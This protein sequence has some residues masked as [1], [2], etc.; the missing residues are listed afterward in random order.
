MHHTDVDGAETDES[1]ATLINGHAV[2]ALAARCR[3]I[4]ATLVQYSTDYVFNGRASEPY[5][6]DC[7]RDPVN[8]Y[9]RSKAVGEE[10][11][12]QSGADFLLIRTSWL[13]AAHGKNFVRTIARA[14]LERPS[15]RVVNDQRGRPTSADQLVNITERLLAAGKRGVFHGCDDGECTWFEFAQSIVNRINPECQV[16]PCKS[17]EFPRPAARPAYSVLDLSKTTAAIG[18]ITQWRDALG[19]TLE[20]VA[21][22]RTAA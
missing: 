6:V 4:G 19:E 5:P 7:F 15:L 14:C 16:E 20:I 2:G 8:A 22:E 13:Y 3:E 21:R 10:L 1:T 9:G 11:L 17:D 12:E 18:P